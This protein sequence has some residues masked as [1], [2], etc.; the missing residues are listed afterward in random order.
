MSGYGPGE[1]DWE[2]EPMSAGAVVALIVVAVFIFAMLA[3]TVPRIREVREERHHSKA[4]D[5]RFKARRQG[6]NGR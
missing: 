4:S 5:E 2:E 1:S 3:T 6:A